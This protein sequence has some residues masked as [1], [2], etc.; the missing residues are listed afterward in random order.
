MRDLLLWGIVFFFSLYAFKN[1][2]APVPI[3]ILMMAIYGN[4]EMPGSIAGIQGLNPWNIL[5][6]VTFL[7]YLAQKKQE[8][9]FWD[10]DG[11]ATLLFIIYFMAIIVSAF[12]LMADQKTLLFYGVEQGTASLFSEYIFNP[13]KFLIP[14]YLVFVGARTPERRKIILWAIILVH[15]GIAV[16]TI[17]S[18]PISAVTSGDDLT[19]VGLK[20]LQKKFSWSKVHTAMLLGC[21]AW[22]VLFASHFLFAN[23]RR[24]LSLALFAVMILAL[25]LTGG[26]MGYAVWIILGS[27]FAFTRWKKGIFILPVA[28]VIV[29]S[30]LP[31]VSERLL[32]GTSTYGQ[33]IIIENT[34][35]VTSGRTV[36]WPVALDR[37]SQSP[38]LG[39]GGMA[40]VRTG[41]T[42]E[43]AEISNIPEGDRG[44]PHPHNAYLRILLDSGVVGA[45]PVLLLW[46]MILMRSYKLCG[47]V[48]TESDAIGITSFCL[49]MGLCL[50]ALGSQDFYPVHG[51]I[52]LW[53]AIGLALRVYI[54]KYPSKKVPL[55]RH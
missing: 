27:V 23:K 33:E 36:A 6:F 14:G 18:I 12:R 28:V 53:A 35:T 9:A 31:S 26:R 15:L 4:S 8:S 21:G 46:W 25:A 37:I 7:A 30:A 3:L 10:M 5:V 39:Y 42:A 19:Q 24:Y 44:F 54:D 51:T 47:E 43:V 50:A 2:F 13:I 1:W 17:R 40:M 22:A 38:L 48:G 32:Q 55:N 52:A 45:I 49:V 29:F 11:K 16:L 41:A 20:V 34:S